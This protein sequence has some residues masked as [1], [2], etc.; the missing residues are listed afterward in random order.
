MKTSNGWYSIDFSKSVYNCN[1]SLKK[2][3][4]FDTSSVLRFYGFCSKRTMPYGSLKL[5][6]QGWHLTY[7]F[8]E[9]RTKSQIIR[10]TEKIYIL[11]SFIQCD[12]HFRDE[13]LNKYNS[14]LIKTNFIVVFRFI[15]KIYPEAFFKKNLI[16]FQRRNL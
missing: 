15:W 8:K 14:L 7:K 12:S 3:D 16:F 13:I 1:S 2:F 6:L 4:D 5:P 10:Q 11:F 9:R